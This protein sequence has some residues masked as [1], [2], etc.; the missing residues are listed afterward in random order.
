MN[1]ITKFELIMKFHCLV[2]VICAS[3]ASITLH[4]ISLFTNY[5]NMTRV[6]INCTT[7]FKKYRYMHC[8]MMFS[9]YSAVFRKFTIKFKLNVFQYIQ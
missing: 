4:A 3:S 2:L 6:Q 9:G 8:M 1:L 5:T 7:D